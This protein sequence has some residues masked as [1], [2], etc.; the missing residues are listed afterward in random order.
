MEK[1]VVAIIFALLAVWGLYCLLRMVEWLFRPSRPVVAAV[2]I[3]DPVELKALDLYLDEALR[4]PRARGCIPP[5]LIDESVLAALPGG[6]LGDD[7]LSILR[8]AGAAW[9]AVD[10]SVPKEGD[11]RV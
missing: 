9:Y 6:H 5:V 4:R 1:T 3:R 7:T 11:G 2:L 8:R 10:L